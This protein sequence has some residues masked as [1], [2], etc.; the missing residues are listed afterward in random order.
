MPN[1][2]M[3]SFTFREV[4]Q[5]HLLLWGNAYAEIEWGPDGFVRG[6]WPIPPNCVQAERDERK[7]LWYRV[8]L[9][10]GI[11]KL[12]REEQM[13]HI[14]G[15]G[16]DGLQG[17]S[18]IG[19]GRGVRMPGPGFGGLEGSSPSGAGRQAIGLGLAA[20]ACGARFVGSG[21]NVGGVIKRPGRIS[22]GAAKDLRGG[23][24]EAYSGLGR[25]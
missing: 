1:P 7:R 2:E 12:L 5:A 11:Q 6:L 4:L 23:I 3:T 10:D 8:S 21:A 19:A 14:P 17:I 15:L 13:L 20:E 25:S 18:P 22:E 16:F 24:N 9:P